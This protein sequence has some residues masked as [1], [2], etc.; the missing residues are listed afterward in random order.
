MVAAA[1]AVSFTP[2]LLLCRDRVRKFLLALTLLSTSLPIG[3]HL[4]YREDMADLGA[5][6]G[7]SIS[8]TTF[9]LVGLWLPALLIPSASPQTR[10][11]QGG[12]KASMPLSLYLLFSA[13]SLLGARDVSL[14][15]Y[16]VALI[17]QLLLL[18]IYIASYICS[19]GDLLL[20][21]RYFLFGLAIQALIM[22]S[23][24]AGLA[25]SSF[26]K[27]ETVVDDQSVAGVTRRLNLCGFKARID[28]DLMTHRTRVGGSLGSP[29]EAAAYLTAGIGIAAGVLLSSLKREYRALAI[30]ASG[31][32]TAALM[33]TFSRGGWIALVVTTG[34]LGYFS[35]RGRCG[36]VAW[37]VPVT[38]AIVL[39]LLVGLLFGSAIRTRLMEDDN[40]S[41]LSRVPL[42]KLAGLII[43]D[44]PL[45]GAGANNFPVAMQ[46]YLTRGFSGEFVYSVH[47]KYLLVWSETGVG[48][49]V[50]FV[51]FLIAIIRRGMRLSC[52]ND[53][54]ISPVALGCVAAVAGEMLH[55]FVDIFRSEPTLQLLCIISGL[56]VA[57]ERLW[58]SNTDERFKLHSGN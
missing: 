21:L 26:F 43:E 22:L 38:V 45:L 14:G 12:W 41:A 56:L 30:A 32:G 3:I 52:Y 46:D 49:L 27:A 53:V 8:V 18:H 48:G 31:L 47:N 15:F 55:M 2:L 4:G 11:T 25:E 33:L 10:G 54:F 58:Q 39:V 17:C 19:R 50:A 44:H 1:I 28:E 9:A 5:L 20:I 37:K 36:R 51:W 34:V 6:G 23:L 40:G 24:A 16:E 42:M 29:N 13:L 7:L 35:L 57:L